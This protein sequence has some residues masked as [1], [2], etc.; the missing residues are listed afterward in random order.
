[1]VSVKG[2]SGH[3]ADHGLRPCFQKDSGKKNQMSNLVV[4]VAAGDDRDEFS[5][6]LKIYLKK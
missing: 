2:K 1:M 3:H 5:Y 6:F 4:N